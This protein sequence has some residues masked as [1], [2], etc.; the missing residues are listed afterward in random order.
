MLTING[1]STKIAYTRNFCPRITP[2]QHVYW[3]TWIERFARSMF[4]RFRCDFTSSGDLVSD[5]PR[6][7][8]LRCIIQM[9]YSSK[10]RRKRR[11]SSYFYP[12]LPSLWIVLSYVAC[13]RKHKYFRKT[14]RYHLGNYA[15]YEIKTSNSIKYLRQYVVVTLES[16]TWG[17]GSTLGMLP[18]LWK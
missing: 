14:F 2:Q 6:R 13:K 15:K 4:C 16:M 10:K 8:W 12:S 17:L 1:Q 9:H 18:I 11:R 3:D 5:S 7:S